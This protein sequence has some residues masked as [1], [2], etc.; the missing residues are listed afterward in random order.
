M[1]RFTGCLMILMWFLAAPLKAQ[2]SGMDFLWFSPDT[3]ALSLNEAVTAQPTGASSLYSNPA[4]LGMSATSVS[5]DYT[6]WIADT[7]NSHAAANYRNR[8]QAFAL[9]L[10]NSRSGR[11]GAGSESTFSYLSVAGGYAYRIKNIALGAVLHY[12]R[13]DFLRY[14]ASGYSAGFGASAVFGNGRIRAGT[15][16]LN[17]GRM[18]ALTTTPQTL[19]TMFKAGL[20]ARVYRFIPPKNDDL[21]VEMSLHADFVQP[22]QDEDAVNDYDPKNAFL[23]VGVAFDVAETISLRGGYK[24]G[25]SDRPFS[26]GVG[27]EMA[28]LQFN[29]AL[30]SFQTGY[31]TVHSIGLEYA[32]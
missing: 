3:Y 25:D 23:N 15:A 27:F 6:L 32:L 18:G 14:N 22:L 1:I 12:L 24:T 28:S 2:R 26:A 10:F 21:P 20:A 5:A 19:P 4:N 13:E 7:Q 11:F 16:V 31:G 29:Y 30:V 17:M 9:G 8:E